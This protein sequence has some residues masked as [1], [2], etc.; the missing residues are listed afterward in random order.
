MPEKAPSHNLIPIAI[1]IA[2]IIIGASIFYSRG[3]GDSNKE[4]LEAN[5]LGIEEPQGIVNVSEDD[6]PALG[7]P[8]AKVIMIEFSDFQ[9]PF[10]GRFF[11]Q[12]LPQI[13][14]DYIKTGKVKFV[15]RDFPFLGQESEWAAEAAECAKEQGKFWQYHDY[16]FEN[17]QGENGGAFSK[18]NLKKFAQGLGL[19]TSQFNGCLDSDKYIDEVRKDLSDGRVAGVTG[20]PTVF[21]NGIR[22]VGAL[23]FSEYQKVIEQE[24][25]K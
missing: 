22:V 4:S 3:E 5:P 9:C 15:Y 23:S 16:L 12:T 25:V 11:S 17:Q 21:I 20:T 24:L 6:D 18:D 8:N 1:I 13:K 19:D 7:N 14:E 10:C 2:G